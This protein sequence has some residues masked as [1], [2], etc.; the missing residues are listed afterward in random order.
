MHPVILVEWTESERGW[1][2]RSDGV[3]LHLS[4]EA[5]QAYVDNY[6]AEEKKRNPSGDVPY[7][8]V[9]PERARIMVS[10]DDDLFEL[11]RENECGLRLWN[12]RYRDLHTSGS[13]QHAQ[14]L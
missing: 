10:V 6:W 2:Q 13:I 14:D 11:I 5:A 7:E 9:R 1:G 4:T 3:S 12:R 8:Y